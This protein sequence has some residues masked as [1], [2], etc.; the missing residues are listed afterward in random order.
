LD[1]Q[2]LFSISQTAIPCSCER[3]RTRDQHA[4]H[5]RPRPFSAGAEAGIAGEGEAALLDEQVTIEGP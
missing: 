3:E 1:F 2:L 5:R 4:E